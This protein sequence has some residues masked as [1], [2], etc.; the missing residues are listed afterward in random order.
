MRDAWY[1][2]NFYPTNKVDIF[3]QIMIFKRP[4]TQQDAQNI[5]DGNWKYC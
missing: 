3:N 2:V 1:D 5:V 4:Y